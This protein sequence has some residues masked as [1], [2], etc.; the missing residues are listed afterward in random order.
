MVETSPSKAG[1]VDSIPSQGARIPHA[2]WPKN[3]G[4]KQKQYC[5]K[6]SKRLKKKSGDAYTRRFPLLFCCFYIHLKFSIIK[7]KFKK[8]IFEIEKFGHEL[9]IIFLIL[10]NYCV[11]CANVIIAILLFLS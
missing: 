1:G 8:V 9:G 7:K 4:I 5:N 6:F 2:S 11:R 3:Q 10:K